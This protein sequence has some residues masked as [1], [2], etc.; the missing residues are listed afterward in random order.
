MI[1]FTIPCGRGLATQETPIGSLRHSP[2]QLTP[3]FETPTPPKFICRKGASCSPTLISNG[4]SWREASS[5]LPP[6]HVHPLAPRKPPPQPRWAGAGVPPSEE[7]RD[8][9]ETYLSFF[10]SFRLWGRE[11][12]PPPPGLQCPARVGQTRLHYPSS[13]Q[14]GHDFMGQRGTLMA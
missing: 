9:Q 12:F 13:L 11:W 3:C 1:G 7:E 4:H 8:R 5:P 6:T 10:L 14:N 2:A